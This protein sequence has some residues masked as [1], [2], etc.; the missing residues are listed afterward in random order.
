MELKK[1]TIKEREEI[2]LGF[3]KLIMELITKYDS[4]T[5]YIFEYFLAICLKGK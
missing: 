5:T 3:H 2:V 4:P 1:L